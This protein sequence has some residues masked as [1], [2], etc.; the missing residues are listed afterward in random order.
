MGNSPGRFSISRISQRCQTNSMKLNNFTLQTLN[1]QLSAWANVENK[2]NYFCVVLYC[3]WSYSSS[4]SSV[5]K[6]S[7]HAL[8][9]ALYRR[10][11]VTKL[12]K[13]ITFIYNIDLYPQHLWTLYEIDISSYLAFFDCAEALSSCCKSKNIPT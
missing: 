9:T 2:M 10:L 7:K 3:T 4:F 8:R 6:V 11:K 5:L 13:C 12:N 1:M